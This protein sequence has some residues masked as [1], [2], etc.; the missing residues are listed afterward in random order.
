[1]DASE[2]E[3]KGRDRGRIALAGGFASHGEEVSRT[4]NARGTVVAVELAG[5]KLLPR[6]KVAKEMQ[7]RY[8]RG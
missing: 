5:S 2:I 6:D 4:R 7:T 8:E 3:V 1:M